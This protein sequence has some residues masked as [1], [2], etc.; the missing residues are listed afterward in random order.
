V[1]EAGVRGWTAGVVQSGFAVASVA[2]AIFVF[3][4]S[5]VAEPMI[6]LGLFRNK[7]LSVSIVLGVI[8]NLTF[9]GLIFVLSLYFQ[10]S[11]GYTPTETGFALLPFT[12][13]MLANLASGHLAKRFSRRVTVIAGGLLSALSFALLH[14]IDDSTP[15]LR[16][17]PSLLLLA[18]GSGISTPAL[19]SSIL[20]SVESSRSAT[21]SAI[22]GASRQVG[23]AIGV[24]LF[25]ALL[26]LPAQAPG[27]V[28]SFDLSV[29]LR[30]VGV[31]LAALFL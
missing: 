22:F 30:L 4:E 9:Y 13:I 10:H 8:T 5:R 31:L 28:V 24:A 11:K 16:I 17:L 7:A 3:N 26:S 14:G 21:A 1:I 12:A 2:I 19:T 29:L 23:S 20:G 15:Y 25:G 6:P 18:I 27:A